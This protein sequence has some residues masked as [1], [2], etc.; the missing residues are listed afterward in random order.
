[1]TESPEEY[2]LPNAFTFANTQADRPSK[3]ESGGIDDAIIQTSNAISQI[4]DR[5]AHA[6]SQRNQSADA[7]QKWAA[8]LVDATEAWEILIRVR[9]NS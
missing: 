9:D 1:M 5:L 3:E 6:S 8:A 2:R 4:I 7:A